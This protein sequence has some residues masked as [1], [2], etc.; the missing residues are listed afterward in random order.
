MAAL[1]S[2]TGER[3]PLYT[4]NINM[5]SLFNCLEAARYGLVQKLFWP[6]SI[7][8]FGANTPKHSPQHT[9]QEPG[10]VYGITK[11]NGELWCNY[12]HKRYGVDVRSLRYPGLVGW[13]SPPGGGTTDYAVDIFHKAVMKEKFECYLNEDTPLS[14]I[15]TE[16]A[17]E[18]TLKL[19]DAP[20]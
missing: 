9:V 7:A 11:K 15:Y 20:S 12:Y 2:S 14:M 1:L 8:A 6:S 10:T 13:R 3:Y 17:I 18:G 4:E 19:M 16:D 5:T